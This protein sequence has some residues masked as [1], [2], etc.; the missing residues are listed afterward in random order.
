MREFFPKEKEIFAG[1]ESITDRKLSHSSRIK[2][3]KPNRK[4]YT[5]RYVCTGPIISDIN[6]NCQ[7]DFFDYARMA[8]AW[9]GSLSE[10]DLNN[11]GYLNFAD[12]SQFA[13]DWLSCNREPASECWQ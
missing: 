3:G 8:D 6:D 12:I 7:A 10:V 11:D 1:I 13:I 5:S 2:T 9:A 4:Q